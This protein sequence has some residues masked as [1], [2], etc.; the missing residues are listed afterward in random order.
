MHDTDF[1]EQILGLSDPW[2][3]ADVRLEMEAHQVDVFVEHGEETKFCC[4][5]CGSELACY[6]HT[7]SRKWR[8]LDTMQFRTI[9]HAATPRV[10][11]PEHGVKQVRLPW[12]EKNSRF[13]LF[14][15]RFAI[16]VLLAT[17]TV[18]GAQSILKTSWE[19]KRSAKGTFR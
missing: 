19:L 16:D 15:E 1:Y 18:K 9:L 4:P 7:P 10:K 14:F 8:H 13:T 6:D 5:E 17:Q 3:V 2:F 12:A 11:C